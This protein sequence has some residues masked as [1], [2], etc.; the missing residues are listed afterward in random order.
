MTLESSG[1]DDLG[2]D[3]ESET[4]PP[5]LQATG[6]I[7]PRYLYIQGPEGKRSIL[8]LTAAIPFISLVTAHQCC[9]QQHTR[10]ADA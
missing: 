4:A 8:H 10:E 3:V 2:A 7:S 5:D 6:S 9:G 1:R